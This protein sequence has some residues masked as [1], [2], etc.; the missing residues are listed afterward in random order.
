MQSL[1]QSTSNSTTIK[2]F[3]SSIETS[4]PSEYFTDSY[5]QSRSVYA[6][7]LVTNNE[8]SG[9]RCSKFIQE[10]LGLFRMSSKV[11]VNMQ[12]LSELDSS[13]MDKKAIKLSTKTGYSKEVITAGF[14]SFIDQNSD[15]L[16]PIILTNGMYLALKVCG[17]TPIECLVTLTKPFVGVSSSLVL[18][19]VLEIEVERAEAF[20]GAVPVRLECLPPRNFGVKVHETQ[21]LAENESK[22]MKHIKENLFSVNSRP[23]NLVLHGA[24]GSGKTT[25]VKDVC[26]QMSSRGVMHYLIDCQ[27]FMSKAVDTIFDQL[28]LVYEECKWHEPVG[29]VVVLEN[30]DLLIENKTHAVDPSS[31]LYHAQIVQCKLLQ[32]V[33]NNLFIIILF[34]TCLK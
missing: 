25:M 2:K 14:V 28:K 19:D 32:G 16:C 4:M 3:L 17:E 23:R 21:W 11:L 12:S 18:N 27:G 29:A 13:L 26:N 7:L 30:L 22:V 6:T 34:W 8:T 9:L 1:K 20:T 15:C 5:S 33:F 24:K 31:Q 10:Q